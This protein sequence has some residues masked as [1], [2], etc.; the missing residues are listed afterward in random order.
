MICRAATFPY[1]E[2]QRSAYDHA[3]DAMRYIGIFLLL[4]GLTTIPIFGPSFLKSQAKERDV[5][6]A[7]DRGESKFRYPDFGFMP[8][9][10]Q[11]EGRVFTLS[12]DYPASLPGSDTI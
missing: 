6:E 4:L 10:H 8:P 3:D 5:Q 11:Y 12:Q 2:E 1:S 9:A 7:G